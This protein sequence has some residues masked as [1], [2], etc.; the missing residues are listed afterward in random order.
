MHPELSPVHSRNHPN[1]TMSAPAATAAP[2]AHLKPHVENLGTTV[3][4]VLDLVLLSWML[5]ECHRSL[6]SM[7]M[8]TRM[9]IMR[10]HK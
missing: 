1:R 3:S 10:T 7:S 8:S 9:S 5:I 6:I 4:P 2:A